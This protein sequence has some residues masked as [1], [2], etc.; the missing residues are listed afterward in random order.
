MN[1]FLVLLQVVSPLERFAA[2]LALERFVGKVALAVGAEMV[3]TLK[4]PLATLPKALEFVSNRLRVEDM[5]S[6]MLK[7]LF[8]V[9]AF[10][11]TRVLPFANPHANTFGFRR[12][13]VAGGLHCY[14]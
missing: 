6:H 12:G 8:H 9:L 4:V 14:V 13:H 7:Q 2:F 5:H 10:M 3:P 11:I 1:A